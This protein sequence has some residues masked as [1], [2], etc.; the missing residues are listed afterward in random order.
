MTASLDF[1]TYSEAGFVFDYAAQRWR[2]VSGGQGGIMAVGAAVYAE[3]PSTEVLI[4]CYQLPGGSLETWVPGMPNPA[5]LLAHVTAGGLVS[6][7]NSFFEWLIWEHVCRRLYGWPALPLENTRDTAA[8]VRAYGLPGSLA[9]AAAAL[10]AAQ[11]KDTTGA[12]LIR[13][14]SIPRSPTKNDKRLRNYMGHDHENA[15]L[16]YAYCAQDVRT[17][18]GLAQAVPPLSPLELDVWKLD[19]QINVRGVAVDVDA[20]RDCQAIVSALSERLTAELRYLT[21]ERIQTASQV[22]EIL[23]MFAD[24]QIPLYNLQADTI[25]DVLGN[26]AYPVHAHP[27]ARRVLEI[28]QALASA[29]VKKLAAIERTV[30]ADGRV[31]GL[32]QYYGAERTGRWAGRGAQPQNLPRGNA[33][34]AKCVECGAL[35]SA[36][37]ESGGTFDQL[38]FTCVGGLEPVKWNFDCALAALHSFASRDVDAATARWGDVLGVMAGCLRSLFVAAPGHRLIA[39]DYSAIE[40]VVVAA[41]AGEE[42]RLDVFRT[43]GKIYETSANKITGIPLDEYL[44]YAERNGEH[45]PDRQKIGK[46]AE[47][48]SAYGG[49]LGAWRAFGAGEHMDDETI[50]ANVRRW[51]DE[52]PSIVNFWYGLERAAIAAIDNPGYTYAY[53]EIG[54]HCD[55]SVLRCILPSGRALVYHSPRVADDVTPWGD[56]KRQIFFWGWNSN[57]KYGPLGWIEQRSYGGRL[58]ENV[59]QAVARDL[60]ANGMLNA[61]RAGYNIVLHVHDEIVAEQPTGHGSVTELEQCMNALPSWAA[62]WP[63][64]ARKGWEGQWYRKE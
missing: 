16:F 14:F 40:A 52:S 47:L 20:V 17:E 29:S 43:H 32:F 26:A 2:S 35:Q 31:R 1:E 44:A 28:R 24:Y 18:Q 23:A 12:S 48:S 54:Y 34:V 8:L 30:C 7:H 36:P 55:G 25:T 50:R 61:A 3:H 45:H 15:R 33:A 63:V 46:I 27:W 11:Q 53:R 57:P 51:R 49:G 37:L 58:T 13:R 39:S 60:M 42:W 4:A 59:V 62:G 22:S 38:C 5:P 19:Q 56:P 6:A 21:N 9:A 64:V 41:L 10:G